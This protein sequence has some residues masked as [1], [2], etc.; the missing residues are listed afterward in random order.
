M[1][2]ARHFFAA[3]LLLSLSTVLLI[4]CG[5]GLDHDLPVQ[6]AVD[7]LLEELT[8]ADTGEDLSLSTVEANL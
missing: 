6:Q 1:K 3:V 7:E 5:V 8:S 2:R 4:G